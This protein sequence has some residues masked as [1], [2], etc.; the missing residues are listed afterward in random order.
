MTTRLLS[1]LMAG[2][3][4]VS[5]T[6]FA[7]DIEQE[8]KSVLA[9]G[10]KEASVVYSTVDEEG[11]P[12]GL[13]DYAVDGQ[14]ISVLNT[15]TNSIYIYDNR[16]IDCSIQLDRFDVVGIK[17]GADNGQTYVLG[18]DFSVF[19]VTNDGKL[20]VMY[21]IADILRTEA[22]F[23]FKVIDN[24]IYVSVS[25]ADG[26]KTYRFSTDNSA[27]SVDA[28][29]V[30]NGNIVDEETYYQSTLIPKG[31]YNCG[32]TCI[33]AI[34]NKDGT[35]RDS[36][37]L[38]SDNFIVGA[39]YLGT[40]TDGNYIIKQY[41]MDLTDK[42]EETIRTIDRNHNVVGC[43]KASEQIM[44]SLN[45]VKV[46]DGN[47]YELTATNAGVSVD[48]IMTENLPEKASFETE[49]DKDA[50]AE[51]QMPL[52]DTTT[53]T[54]T[55][56][57]VAATI[58]RSTIMSNAKAYHNQF[59]W[60]CS[61]SNLAALANWTRPRYVSG[62][63]S[64]NYMPYCWGG[65]ST[66]SQ[67]KAGMTNGGRVGNINTSTAGH[68]S[69][70]YGLDCSGYVS[71]CWGLTSKRSTSTLPNVATK[72]IYASLQR[73]DMIDKAGSHVV[74]Y[75]KADGNGGYILY[76]ATKLNSYDRVAYTIRSIASLQNGSY[77]AYRYNNVS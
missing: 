32:H 42:V 40:N 25:E 27:E 18:N 76:E 13:E 33:V 23:N 65:F 17:V 77:V 73:G 74:L 1:C 21:N 16:K 57:T 38:H 15:A 75:E 66:P 53:M 22:I 14:N 68:V 35:E 11:T 70:T 9:L 29:E 48:Q 60:S 45:Q 72:I 47:I 4:T 30:I 26:S 44:N 43:M 59:I 50:V 62:A 41:D 19:K 69:N 67:Y 34:L 49:L 12:K 10:N 8:S 61:S 7:T 52:A 24:D 64:Y 5:A 56:I 55:D 36:K 6:A 54:A 39:Q 2:A 51:R 58:S 37:T 20:D 31:D 46:I 71:R 28:V 63:G 3:M